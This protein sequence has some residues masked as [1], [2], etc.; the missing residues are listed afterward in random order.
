ME[1]GLYREQATLALTGRC[2][3]AAPVNLGPLD[4]TILATYVGAVVA[5]GIWNGRR[6]RSAEDF[7]VGGRDLP[8]WALLLSIVA[9]ETSTVTF[10]SVPGVAWQGD[11]TFLQLPLGYIAGR[12]AVS[13]LLLPRFFRG[14]FFTAYEVLHE[15]F[16]PDVR[17]VTSL[18]FLVTRTLGDGL[19][20]FLG[21]IVLQH[22]AG[23]DL[24]TSVVLLGIATIAYT[25]VGGIRAV[26]WT[27]AVQLV[28]YLGGAAIALVLMIQAVDGGLDAIVDTA[29]ADGKLRVF[30][31]GFDLAQPY[32][33]WAGMIG[34]FVVA[35]GTHGVDQLMVQRYLCARSEHQARLA[36]ALSGPAVFLQFAFF[37]VIGTALYAFYAQ[38]PP[39]RPFARS[40]EVFASFI[41]DELPAGVLGIVLGAVFSAAMSTLS[42]SLNSTATALVH[43]LLPARED[44]MRLR[45]AK[46]ATIGFGIAQISVGIAG[47]MLQR[48]DDSI[49]GLALAIQSYA[50]G[51]ILGV[52]ALGRW[53]SDRNAALFGIAIGLT[54]TSC[55]AWSG[56]IAW[57]WFVLIG[58]TASFSSGM[59]AHLWLRKRWS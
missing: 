28:V 32:Q 1:S 29:R 17:R 41:V 16:G 23:L 15:R 51:I 50:L 21:A 37:L 11:L 43:D 2:R 24:T 7:M 55:A 6:N 26:V 33:F 8:W 4:A 20:L 10:L 27:D 49:I 58:S 18:L 12:L 53:S 13:F 34:G 48:L 44:E 9:T 52:F 56:G 54:A 25:L 14:K 57:P 30:D 22:V 59:L 46:L 38:H 45:L 47:P 36:L 35:F 42:S 39:D 5:F 40:D 3:D 19:R 31:F